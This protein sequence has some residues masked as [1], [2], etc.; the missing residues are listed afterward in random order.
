MRTLIKF[1]RVPYKEGCEKNYVIP[2]GTIIF[3]TN[4]PCYRIQFGLRPTR[5][6]L[7]DGVSTF[8]KLKLI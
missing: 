1:C 8:K 6:L 2:D 7:G 5:I 3:V 4:I